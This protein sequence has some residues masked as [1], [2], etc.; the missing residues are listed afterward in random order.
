MY[1]FPQLLLRNVTL[2]L[3][4]IVS[5]SRVSI[6][7]LASLLENKTNAHAQLITELTRQTPPLENIKQLPEAEQ[8]INAEQLPEIL[9]KISNYKQLTIYN[10]TGIKLVQFSNKEPINSI[11]MAFP[12]SKQVKDI[13]NVFTIEYQLNYTDESVLVITFI[14]LSIVLS[15]F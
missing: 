5:I 15:L 10:P 12:D 7:M 14:V 1:T 4:F 3:V 2:A 9:L 6:V 13:H 8:R 11:P